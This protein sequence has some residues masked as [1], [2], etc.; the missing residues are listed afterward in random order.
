MIEWDD[1]VEE[2]IKQDMSTV[3]TTKKRSIIGYIGGKFY[4]APA[5]ISL[6]PPHDIYVEPFFG[7][8]HVFFQKSPVPLE[9]INDLYRILFCFYKVLQEPNLFNR[10]VKRVWMSTSHEW[11]FL[12]LV[13]KMDVYIEQCNSFSSPEEMMANLTDGD[14]VDIAVTF[15]LWNS[16]TPDG[17]TYP[18]SRVFPIQRSTRPTKFT[19]HRLSILYYMHKRLKNARIYCRDYKDIILEYNFPEALIY[20]DP[21]Y[22]HETRENTRYYIKE[23]SN[24]EHEEMVDII[25]DMRAKIAL[26]GYDNEIYRRLEEHGWKKVSIGTYSKRQRKKE[27]G[28]KSFQA[29]EFVW[30]NYPLSLLR[31]SH[32]VV[33]K[34][35]LFASEDGD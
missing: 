5:I 9:I 31:Q 4:Q 11:L 28:E 21:P 2:T 14:L 17:G 20:L 33:D 6:F 23:F 10:F 19:D 1:F 12:E 27:M 3:G 8:G 30:I 22:V 18:Q 35:G 24:K 32:G 15:F 34:T 16:M 13:E 25:K 29:E 26:S 7:A